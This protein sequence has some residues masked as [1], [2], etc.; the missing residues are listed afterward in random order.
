MLIAAGW[1]RTRLP[2]FAQLTRKAARAVCRTFW[3]AGWSNLDIVHALDHLPAAFGA[4][5]GTPIGRRPELVDGESSARLRLVTRPPP[6]HGVMIMIS[7]PHVARNS[8]MRP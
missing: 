8:R 6:P 1:L 7:W 3:V 2:V 4:R 5:A